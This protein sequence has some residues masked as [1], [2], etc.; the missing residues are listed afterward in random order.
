ML[1]T[2]CDTVIAGG[3]D[4]GQGGITLDFTMVIIIAMSEASMI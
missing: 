2:P 4:N 3:S 1:E